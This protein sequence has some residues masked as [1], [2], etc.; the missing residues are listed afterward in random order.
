MSVTDHLTGHV[1]DQV[2]TIDYQRWKDKRL[3]R[4][5][6]GRRGLRMTIDMFGGSSAFTEACRPENTNFSTPMLIFSAHFAKK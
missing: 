3:R 6:N 2:G 4:L 1:T 5:F